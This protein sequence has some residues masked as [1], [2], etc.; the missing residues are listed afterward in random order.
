MA[1]VSIRSV[2]TMESPVAVSLNGLH[3]AMNHIPP[4][5]DEFFKWILSNS[6]DC[7]ACW[8]LPSQ[9]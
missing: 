9:V 1:L 3:L 7:S 8:D 5:K 6:R 4:D 2:A